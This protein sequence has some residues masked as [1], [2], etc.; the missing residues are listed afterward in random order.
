MQIT[1]LGRAAGEAENGETAEE[2][3]ERGWAMIR[4]AIRGWRDDVRVFEELINLRSDADLESV[5]PAAAE[6]HAELLAEAP[7]MIEIEFLDEPDLEERFF[8][9]GTDPTRMVRPIP[10]GIK[11]R[12]TV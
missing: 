11:L 5:L 7:H 4:I 6:R 1:V 9:F 10:I 12:G 2:A 3:V 8:R